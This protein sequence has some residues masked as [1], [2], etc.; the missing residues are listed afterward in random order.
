MTEISLYRY[1]MQGKIASGRLWY[2][3][4][5]IHRKCVMNL[6]D[7][8]QSA[9][10]MYEKMTMNVCKN[11]HEYLYNQ[12]LYQYMLNYLQLGTTHMTQQHVWSATYRKIIT[13]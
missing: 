9:I 10:I 13:V 3:P 4:H 12:T 2:K 11:D 1:S 5:G 7:K 6:S 8:L